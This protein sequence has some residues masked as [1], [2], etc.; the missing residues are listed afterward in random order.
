[1][2]Y[3]ALGAALLAAL[4]LFSVLSG[5]CTA[6]QLD[7]VLSPL[8]QA[9]SAVQRDDGAAAS[10]HVREAS[11][12]WR[13][14]LPYLELLQHHEEVDGISEGFARL[15]VAGEERVALCAELIERLRHLQ[16]LDCLTIGNFL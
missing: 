1:M 9:L 2:K 8:S 3:L 15:S 6:K 4:L 13:A 5:S 10:R 7:A 14:A 16:A 11:D 12:A